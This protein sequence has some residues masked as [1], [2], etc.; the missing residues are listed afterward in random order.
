MAMTATQAIATMI[1]HRFRSA[2]LKHF[3]KNELLNNLH[4]QSIVT[5]ATLAWNVAKEPTCFEI[6][7]G[8]TNY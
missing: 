8:D 4:T 5:Q 3:T 6:V 2:S 1:A 7:S